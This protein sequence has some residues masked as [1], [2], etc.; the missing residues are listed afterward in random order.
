MARVWPTTIPRAGEPVTTDSYNQMMMEHLEGFNGNINEGQLEFQQI[1]TTKLAANACNKFATT[2]CKTDTIEKY[3]SDLS[4][5]WN[6]IDDMTLSIECKDGLLSGCFSGDIRKYGPAATATPVVK[7]D[8]WRVGIFLDGTMIYDS[9]H[10]GEEQ[11]ALCFPFCETI[12]AGTHTVEVKVQVQIFSQTHKG[13]FNADGE[14][15][16]FQINDRVLWLRNRY[17]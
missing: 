9:D 3:P 15:A 1:T 4:T 16:V 7:V 6:L 10:I 13:P 14:T 17:R 2:K 8:P 11:T 5:G 12:G